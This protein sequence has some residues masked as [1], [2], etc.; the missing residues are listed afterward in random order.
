MFVP[1]LEAK[2]QAEA[3][4]VRMLAVSDDTRSRSAPEV[5]TIA[6]SG[7]PRLPR[8]QLDQFDGAGCHA[9]GHLNRIAAE[10]ARAAK[11]PK[12]IDAVEIQGV[13]PAGLTPEEFRSFLKQDMALW[14]EAVRVAGVKLDG[15]G[16]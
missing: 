14:A 12:F 2:P 15:N 6:E 10:F 3:G 16:D 4:K 1:L 8:H 13:A 7:Y 5:P 9:Q 11:D